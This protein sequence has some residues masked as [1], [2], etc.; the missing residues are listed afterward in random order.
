MIIE[1]IIAREKR[2]NSFGAFGEII[3]YTIGDDCQFLPKYRGKNIYV[4]RVNGDIVYNAKYKVDVDYIFEDLTKAKLHL[5]Y[6]NKY[7][8]NLHITFLKYIDLIDGTKI[9]F[10]QDEYGNIGYSICNPKD[11]FL[12][13]VGKQ[14][15]ENRLIFN[16]F[17]EGNRRT[18]FRCSEKLSY[19]YCGYLLYG[20]Y[21]RKELPF[22]LERDL[23]MFKRRCIG[24][25]NSF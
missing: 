25:M 18:E 22:Y 5:L 10:V 16:L 4:P 6:Y 9:T 15:A 23:E 17:D 12:K 24:L 8:S 7:K 21:L 1:D 11:Q 2:I 19:E 13:R 3:A 14:L 20:L